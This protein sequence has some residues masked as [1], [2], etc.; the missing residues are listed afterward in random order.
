MKS[1]WFGSRAR[2]DFARLVTEADYGTRTYE[3]FGAFLECAAMSL[4]QAV[5][6]FVHNVM[7]DGVSSLMPTN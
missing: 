6:K 3:L 2:Y 1:T 5:H 7:C 4:K